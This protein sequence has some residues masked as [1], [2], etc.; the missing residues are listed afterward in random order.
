[1]KVIKSLGVLLATTALFAITAGAATNAP[2]VTATP[3]L[4]PWTLSVAGGGN[5]TWNDTAEGTDTAVGATFELGH[6]GKFIVPFVAGLRQSV[7]WGDSEGSNWQ[8]GTKLFADVPVLKLGNSVQFDVGGNAGL[9]YG[10]QT[11]VWVAAP[12]VVGRVYLTR[13]VDL[14]GRVEYP[15]NLNEGKADESLVYSLGLR[16]RF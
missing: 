4:G 6:D 15:F 10:N 8:F 16:V 14:F 5:T 7:G 2:V 1:M 11:P 12:E 13:N 9:L 3:D